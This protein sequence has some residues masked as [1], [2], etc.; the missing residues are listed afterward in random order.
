MMFAWSGFVC[1]LSMFFKV[2]TMCAFS[3]T[4]ILFFTSVT[5]DHVLC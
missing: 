1:R 2:F 5:L 3:F 4:N